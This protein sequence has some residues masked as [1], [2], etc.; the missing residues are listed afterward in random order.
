M[1]ILIA[2]LI[3]GLVIALAR[4]WSTATQESAVAPTTAGTAP[5]RTESTSQ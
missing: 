3:I 2:F 4:M 1:D 5:A